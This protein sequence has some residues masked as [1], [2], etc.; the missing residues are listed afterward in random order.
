MSDTEKNI[1]TEETERIAKL[2]ERI[3]KLEKGTKVKKPKIPK[4]DRPPPKG[5]QKFLRDYSK[6]IREEWTAEGREKIKQP[7]VM[8]E[9]GVRWGKYT[10]EEKKAY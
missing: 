7:D 9:C 4:E 8:R 2:E 10:A 3:A 6:I 1:K 5:Y